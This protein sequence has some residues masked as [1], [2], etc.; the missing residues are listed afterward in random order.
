MMLNTQRCT[1]LLSQQARLFS[2]G[3][4][5]RTAPEVR[6]P[7][8]DNLPSQPAKGSAAQVESS[9]GAPST[10]TMPGSVP[11]VDA[12]DMATAAN[13]ATAPGD[14]SATANTTTAKAAAGKTTTTTTTTIVQPL[15]DPG[16]YHLHCLTSHS[17]TILTLTNHKHE[18]V[19]GTS[20]GMCGFKKAARGGYEAGFRAMCNMLERMRDKED[21]DAA[22][23]AKERAD[24]S[25]VQR[26]AAN[27]RKPPFHPR[28]IDLIVKDFGL[29][30]EAVM[31]ALHGVEGDRYRGLVRS[32]IDA[33]PLKFGGVRARAVRRL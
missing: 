24:P 19:M 20:A 25:R 3:R 13:A 5:V 18:V 16:R 23:S 11:G 10:P 2:A 22:K 8:I 15:R 21:A 30:R 31:K 33:T 12:S 28:E 14:T 26:V 27:K 9:T 32:V 4:A 1:R 7:P 17:N 29:G 6:P